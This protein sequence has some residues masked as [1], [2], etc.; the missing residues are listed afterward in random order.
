[1]LLLFGDSLTQFGSDRGGWVASLTHRYSRKLDLLNRGLSGYTTRWY[2][3]SV[4][5]N[6]PTN[7]RLAIVWL[8]ANDAVL[9][10]KGVQHV[11]LDEYT[12]RL[13]AMLKKIHSQCERI[14]VLTP[15]PLDESKW[16]DRSNRNTFEYRKRAIQVTQSLNLVVIDIWNVFGI[17][18][19]ESQVDLI[20]MKASVDQEFQNP[21]QLLLDYYLND[22]LH[23]SEEG[24]HAVYGAVVAEIQKSF[25]DLD[26]DTMQ[27]M[28]PWWR[29][30]AEMNKEISL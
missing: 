19:N 24:N 3:Q 25:P 13:E 23:L 11:P 27:P 10:G 22:G 4:I 18:G 5:E 1:M 30:R 6:V 14:I 12:T 28:F 8:G 17:F 16:P 29:D 7:T 21:S 2:P 9:P 26:P 15:P 20:N